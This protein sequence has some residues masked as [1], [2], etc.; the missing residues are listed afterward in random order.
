M[1]RIVICSSENLRFDTPIALEFGIERPPCLL[2][3]IFFHFFCIDKL[4][5][6]SRHKN[7]GQCFLIWNTVRYG[8]FNLSTD[9]CR[10]GLIL[11]IYQF[12]TNF[13]FRW[14]LPIVYQISTGFLKI[15]NFW[16][17]RKLADFLISTN[18]N[19]DSTPIWQC[20]MILGDKWR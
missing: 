15:C 9:F 14:C 5:F 2:R 13:F 3:K 8:V 20:L 4:V 19:G 7:S 6:H 1:C 12:S 10:F 18:L 17:Q 16:E 11:V